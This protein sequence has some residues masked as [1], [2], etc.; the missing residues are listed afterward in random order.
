MDIHKNDTMPEPRTDYERA[1][2]DV[3]RM[4]ESFLKLSKPERERLLKEAYAL[5]APNSDPIKTKVVLS[6]LNKVLG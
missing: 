1:Y 4:R 5:W 3:V 2:Q 6:T